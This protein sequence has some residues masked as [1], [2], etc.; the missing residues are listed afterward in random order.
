[1]PSWTIEEE[2]VVLFYASRR[3]KNATIVDLLA[4]KCPA[5]DP[6]NV[7]NIKQVAHKSSRLRQ[8]LG[9]TSSAS[10]REWNRNIVDEWLFSVMDEDDVKRLLEFD[11]ETAAIIDEVSGLE[12]P[13]IRLP[14]VEQPMIEQ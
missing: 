11:G 9:G 3:V 7:R 1:M 6:A 14:C 2:I 12:E 5:I 13:L 4:K 10:G 8:A